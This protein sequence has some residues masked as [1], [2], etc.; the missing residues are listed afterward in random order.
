MTI[1]KTND[2]FL[3]DAYSGK[4]GFASGDFL[5]AHPRESVAKLKKR[6]ELA[7]YP[8]F[9]RKITDVFVGYLWKQSPQRTDLSDLYTQFVGN[10]DGMGMQLDALLLTYQRL[11]MILGSVYLIVDKSSVQA[12][13][14]ADETAPYLSVRL[15]SQ[16]VY[17]EKDARGQW[18]KLTFSEYVT[19]GTT[20]VMRYRSFTRAGWSV[21]STIDGV[22]ELNG[23]YTLGCVPVV[24]LHAAPPL[25]PYASRSDSFFYDLAQL[26]WD[27]YNLR[28]ELRELFRAQAFAIL[29]LPVTSDSERERLK[30][31]TISTENAL[32]FNPVGGG[33]PKFIAPPADPVELYMAQIAQTV[34]DIY[35]IANLEFVGGVQQSGVALSFHFQEANSS[36][37][38]MAEQCETAE[39]KIMDLVH[40]WMGA[41]PQGYVAY[42]NDFNLTDLAQTLNTAMDAITLSLGTEFDRA[43]KK[44]LAKQILG[45]DIAPEV[46]AAIETE[47][48]AG[49]DVYGN[50]IAAAVA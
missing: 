14:K 30:D 17:E 6:K 27:L 23:S 28:S 22:G 38:T 15:P 45:N 26:N 43:I 21:S 5:V 25:D 9:C 48:D 34:L 33:E 47:I 40:L 44:R 46:I 11:A 1:S 35:R 36:L 8:N 18:V 49:G 42:N 20:Q 32:T 19:T 24:A 4:G 37:R 29:T 31:L 12:T 10:A 16:L 13:T 3:L 2:Q 7:V 50:R 41:T 39:K